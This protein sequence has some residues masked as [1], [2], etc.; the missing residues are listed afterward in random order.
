MSQLVSLIIKI[1]VVFD[2]NMQLHRN[3]RLVTETSPYRIGIGT[4]DG[5]EGII[6]DVDGVKNGYSTAYLELNNTDTDTIKTEWE[7]GDN[8]FINTKVWYNGVL[9]EHPDRPFEI[10]KDR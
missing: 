6:S 9:Q 3:I 10:I 2:T 8:Y 7:A 1:V 4:Y 5:L